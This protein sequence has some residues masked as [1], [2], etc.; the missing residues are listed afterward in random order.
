M[1]GDDHKEVSYLI[2][3]L[4]ARPQLWDHDLDEHKNVK[5]KKR[6]HPDTATA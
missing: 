6:L 2:E 4:H 1:T 3:L 5:S